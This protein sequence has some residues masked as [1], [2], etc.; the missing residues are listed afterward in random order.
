SWAA[1]A[2]ASSAHLATA[3]VAQE[4]CPPIPVRA[5]FLPSRSS[6]GR[7]LPA[8]RSIDGPTTLSAAAIKR[9]LPKLVAWRFRAGSC[10]I[11]R[12]HPILG[13]LFRPPAFRGCV[14]RI[15]PLEQVAH[16]QRRATS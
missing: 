13:S 10:Y 12:F 8:C 7:C 1:C 2:G 3:V 11:G 15:I 14:D 9:A 6:P 5:W 16:H 4:A